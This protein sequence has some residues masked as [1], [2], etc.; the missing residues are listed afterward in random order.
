VTTATFPASLCCDDDAVEKELVK[1]P[2]NKAR[3]AAFPRLH[4]SRTKKPA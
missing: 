1:P 2:G 3:L 4:L